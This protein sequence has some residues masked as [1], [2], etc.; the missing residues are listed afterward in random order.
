M[1]RSARKRTG[2]AKASSPVH[3]AFR[4]HLKELIGDE[5]DALQ[6]ALTNPS[7]VSIRVNPA[8][9]AGP[10]ADPIPWCATGRYL[11]ERPSFT[12][13]P[14]LHAG[15]YYVQEASSMLLEQ[16]VKA[17]GLLG[18]D[19][20][21]LDLCA[22]PGGKTTHLRSL[23]SPG[24]LIVA[25]EI[26]R[27]RQGIVQENLWK[28][29]ASNTVICG[30]TPHDLKA[31]PDFFDLILVDA[32]CSGEG[33]F[34]K[35]PFAREQWSPALVK[36]CAATQ[37]AI[38]GPA[39]HSLK[40][41]GTLIYC[42]CTW[43]ETENELQLARLT[44]LGASC[45]DIPVDPSWGV[46]RAERHGITGL[47]C[48]PHRMNGE[49]FFIAMLRK[50]GGPMPR[51]AARPYANEAPSEATRWLRGDVLWNTIEQNAILFAVQQ[52]WAADIRELSIGLRVLSPGI[53]LAEHKG[54][55]LRPHPALAL[56]SDLDR[57][58]FPVVELD[59]S[60]ALNYLRGVTIPATDVHGTALACYNGMALGWLHGA[61]NRW[62]NRWPAPW[63]IRA[64]QPSAPNV[65][66]ADT[67]TKRA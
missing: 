23:L 55:D 1:D 61:G 34:R 58:A 59:R 46:V 57:N 19:I 10:Q 44:K 29:G 63:R 6:L 9:W 66:W 4:E 54:V 20:R 7:P 56:S 8:K 3:P 27:K 49:G 21:A 30:S 53:P 17:S 64:Q 11:G 15:C 14:L 41:G 13:D 36:H 37:H 60:S 42:T 47:R 26:D 5:A 50:E 22:A 18:S 24:S 43:E 45:M 62:N 32:P 51:S 39:W 31:L 48:Y 67:T 2:P 16:A 38:L 65:S 40:P 52:H 33:M 28:W 25:N 35:D 12:F